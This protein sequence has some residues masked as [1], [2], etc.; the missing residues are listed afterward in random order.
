DLSRAKLN[1][2]VY[3]EDVA[4]GPRQRFAFGNAVGERILIRTEQL[5]GR[6]ESE[7]GG[8]YA[9]AMHEYAFLKRAFGALHRYEQEDWAFH[10]FKVN[11]RRCR[12]RSWWRPWTKVAQFCDWLFLDQGCGYCTNPM[13]AVRAALLIMLG[14]ALIYAAGIERFH[15][16][17]G[18]LP[19]PD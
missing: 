5:R 9:E 7:E 13:R 15:V 17:E 1:D 3:L 18:K 4:Q 6:L 8:N 12:A 19:F 11:Q 16:D 14:F 10:R 2:Y